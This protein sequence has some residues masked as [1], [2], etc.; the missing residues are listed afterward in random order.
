MTSCLPLNYPM[1]TL[2]VSTKKI[3]YRDFA[4]LLSG[5]VKV[6]LTKQAEKNIENS[7]RN[8]SALLNQDTTIYGVNTGFGNLSNISINKSDQKLLQKNLVRSHASGVGNPIDIGTVRVILFLK[9]LTYAK[10]Y[11]GIRLTLVKK[12]IQYINNDIMP[13]IPMKGSVGASGDL[14]PLGHMALSLIGEGKVYLRGKKMDTRA[15]LKKLKIKPLE[16]GP[17]EGLSLINGTQV[18]TAFSIKACID[19]EILLKTADIAGALSI[20]NSFSSR[21]V[22]RKDIHKLKDHDGQQKSAANVYKMLRGSEIVN[23]HS[24]CDKVQDPYSFRCIPH[25]HGASRDSFKLSTVMIN[26]EINSLSDNPLVMDGSTILSSGHFH[27]EH[28]AQALDI[29]GIAFS[30]IG[31]ISERRIHFFMKGIDPLIPPFI[32][33]N[34]GIES[35]YMIAHVTASAL[36]SENKT[37]AHP[38]SIDSLPTSGGQEDHVSMAPWAGNKL[39]KI[40]RNVASILAI[41]LIV[42]GA[43]N[44]LAVSGI[45]AGKGTA[46][47]LKVLNNHCRF[48]KGDRSLSSE[49][50]EITKLILS[51]NILQEVSKSLKL[52]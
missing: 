11:S 36:A 47:V 13:Y 28:I 21:K 3:S 35:G 52:E 5:P 31:A 19:G 37:L 42:S 22:F 8:L 33:T 50:E 25:V 9:L 51:G 34:P 6:S 44:S 14:A 7:H 29:I 46:P 1:E 23:S 38:A 40:Q 32:A 17:K 45:R 43:A 2:L 4:P 16:L 48:A 41:E 30:E 12:I 39:F 15:A 24:N 27:A 49:I 10:G 26:N 18:S 20:E